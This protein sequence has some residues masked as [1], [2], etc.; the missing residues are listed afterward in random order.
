MEVITRPDLGK[1]PYRLRCRFRIG[2]LP[3]ERWLEKAKYAAA[4]QFVDDMAGRGFEYVDH[5]GFRMTGPYPA[6]VPV[7]VR[8][9]RR[10][11]AREMLPGVMAVNPYRAGIETLACAVPLLDESEYWEYGLA[12]V[13]LHV[14]ILT[15]TPD[16]HE[17]MH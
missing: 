9:P 8:V 3:G 6:L 2:A 15:D 12:G 11:T 1:K 13:F 4:Q 14:A 5:F 16:P 10:L 17:E 7:T